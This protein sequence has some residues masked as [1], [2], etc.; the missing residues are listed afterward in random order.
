LPT[1]CPKCKQPS[2]A[3]LGVGT[4]RLESQ[5]GGL[6]P[7]ARLGRLDRDTV[8]SKHRLEQIL[9]D[10][11]AGRSDILIGTQMVTKGHDFPGVTLVGVLNADAAL[12]FP[13]FR[14][15]ERTFQLITQ[16]AGRAGRGAEP[17]RVLV[18]SYNPE[19]YAIGCA[20]ANDHQG[21]VEQELALRRELGY[22]PYG[23]L[24]MVRTED[25]AEEKSLAAAKAMADR[26]KEC[27][28]VL[29]STG[30]VVMGPAPAPIAK[31]RGRYRHQV[32][33]KSPERGPL[34]EL[35]NVDLKKLIKGETRLILDIDPINML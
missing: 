12:N 29:K 34:H 10:F 7:A 18:Q 13:D 30:L 16:V 6:F 4:E 33:I 25:A 27:C 21:F 5:L 28:Q 32:L 23:H 2:L 35:L 31:L 1:E 17:G 22:P 3:L 9:G 14:A 8:Q 15:A 24:A 11:G 20:I 19:H 26:L